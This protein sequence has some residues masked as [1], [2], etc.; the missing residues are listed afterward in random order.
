MRDHIIRYFPQAIVADEVPRAHQAAEHATGH[1]RWAEHLVAAYLRQRQRSDTQRLHIQR[2]RQ[3]R[4]QAARDSQ[5]EVASRSTAWRKL[6]GD[7]ADGDGSGSDDGADAAPEYCYKRST[8]AAVGGMP[9]VAGDPTGYAAVYQCS[10]KAQAYNGAVYLVGGQL[11]LLPD[12]NVTVRMEK[13]GLVT[14]CSKR[15]TKE[16]AEDVK[17]TVGNGY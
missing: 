7:R 8:L 3:Q 2:Q 14:F 10:G 12:G 6:E 15:W 11:S 5:A 16:V 9:A 1:A 13:R 17:F 4:A